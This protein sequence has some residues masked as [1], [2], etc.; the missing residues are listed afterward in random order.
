MSAGGKAVYETSRLDNGIQVVTETIPY[1]RSVAIGF[2]FKVGSCNESLCNL[3]ITHFIEHMLFKGTRSRSAREIA[4]AVDAVGGQLNAFTTKEHTCYYARIL[5]QHLPLAVELLADMVQNSLFDEREIE[6]EKGVVLEEIAMYEDAPDELVHDLVLEAAWGN[7]PLGRS[8]LGT[9]ASVKALTREDLMEFMAQHYVGENLVVAA[10]GNVTHDEVVSLIQEHLG[11]LPRRPRSVQPQISQVPTLASGLLLRPK[12]TEQVHIC[13][14]SP[15]ISCFAQDKYVMHLLDTILGGGMSSRLFQ[16]LR[17]ERGLVYSAYSYHTGFQQ[18]GIFSVYA[19]TSPENV[20]TVL[21][22][23]YAE[24]E[25]LATKPVAEEELKRAK[26]QIKGGLML[27]LESITTRMN[28]LAKHIL[29]NKPF[30]SLDE[31]LKQIDLVEA[32]DVRKMAERVFSQGAALA[33]IGS[34]R[35]EDVFLPEF[36][37]TAEKGR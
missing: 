18:T 14:G 5:D 17:E 37:R 30:C 24:F 15:G 22:L 35:P 33:V 11:A 7:H 12:G 21:T 23:I 9:A 26:E 13:T 6:K 10:V 1:V 29:Y 34:V 4:E 3:G 32:E 8:T 2:W 16:G 20:K 25:K 27:A 31:I 19:G 36:A 28:R